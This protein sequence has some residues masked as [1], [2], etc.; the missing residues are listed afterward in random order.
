M[1]GRLRFSPNSRLE[2][3][4]SA[5]NRDHPDQRGQDGWRV[6]VNPGLIYALDARTS[7]ET[8]IDLELVDARRIAMEAVWPG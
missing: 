1:R 4:L 8:D 5:G 2:V 7:I 3:N 6:S